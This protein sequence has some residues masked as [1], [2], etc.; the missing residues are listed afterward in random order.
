MEKAPPWPRYQLGHGGSTK[1]LQITMKR[2]LAPLAVLALCALG[3][4]AGA[5]PLF[6]S[7]YLGFTDI[8]GDG[9]LSCGETVTVRVFYQTDLPPVD[10]GELQGVLT[11]PDLPTV[12]GLDYL[13]G[14]LTIDHLHT[15][16]CA[17]N[18]LAGNSPGDTQARV[19]V[20][21]LQDPVALPGGATLALEYQARYVN[22]SSPT[23]TDT[24]SLQ[25]NRTGPPLFASDPQSRVAASTCSSPPPLVSIRKSVLGTAN[26]GARLVYNLAIANSSTNPL[27]GDYAKDIVPA[28]TTFDAADSSPGWFCT[29]G[30]AAGASCSYLFSSLPVGTSNLTFAVTIDSPLPP[31]VSN[32][33]NTACVAQSQVVYGCDSVSSPIAGAPRLSITKSIL[34]GTPASPGGLVSFQITVQ[35]TG[36]RGSSDVVVTDSLPAGTVYVASGSGAWTC[37]GPTCTADLGTLPAGGTQRINLVLKTPSP[38]PAGI[39]SF[40]N[41]ACAAPVEGGSPVCGS[42]TFGVDGAPVLNLQKTLARGDGTPGTP[43]AFALLV[44]NDGDQ[45]A[46]GVTVSETLPANTTVDLAASDPGW[47]CS[48]PTCTFNLGSLAAGEQRS[49]TFVVDVDKPLPAGVSQITNTACAAAPQVPQACG[50]VQVNTQGHVVLST[51]KSLQAPAPG[52]LAAKVFTGDVVV[53]LLT[54]TNSGDQDAAGVVLK[55]TVPA[56]TVFEPSQSDAAWSCQNGGA[57]GAACSLSIG[58]L[59]A[60]GSVSKLFAV[61]VGTL[62]PGVY[63]VH[64]VACSTDAGGATGCGQVDTPPNAPASLG[65]ELSARLA[66]DR[67]GSGDVTP[68]DVLEYTAVLRNLGSTTAEAVV[69]EIHAPDNSVLQAGSVVTSAGSVLTGNAPSDT[70]IQVGLGDLP[71]GAQVTVTYKVTIPLSLA[72]TVTQI[73]SQG[74]VMSGNA[75]SILTDDPATPAVNDPTVTPVR[76][77]QGP[78]VADVPTLNQAGLLT[79]ALGLAG[80][81]TRL[82]RRKSQR[83]G[84]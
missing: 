51:Q 54:V 41:Q 6:T 26:P 36:D 39:N 55:E 17:A 62:P 57:A 45:D 40:T 64:N 23:F 27:G 72:S 52:R 61:R 35:N 4:R 50:T 9:Q 34:A 18:F 73:V 43:L 22:P 3:G 5:D 81:A 46:S 19:A 76:H 66:E 8:N 65:A 67:D 24:A 16:G 56:S 48:P 69:F 77:P 44:R 38:L 1:G 7:R 70:S 68:G 83:S 20:T 71:S 2:I 29:N 30:G 53:Y 75:A 74:G 31:N 47:S 15:T 60:G 13:P 10:P 12:V 14:T 49:L 78:A 21:C 84:P 59:G 11:M 58:A 42:A 25:L 28:N 82:V 79:L 37:S 80:A 63:T 33:S 32:I